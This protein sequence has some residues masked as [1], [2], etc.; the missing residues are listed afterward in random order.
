MSSSST[1]R[2]KVEKIV[3]RTNE[4]IHMLANEP[5]VG[6]FHVQVLS[7]SFALARRNNVSMQDH[8]VRVLPG[9]NE[10]RSQVANATE[11]VAGC[12]VDVDYSN[13]VLDELM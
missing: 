4:A 7:F 10:T 9:V 11:A 3:Q 5:S 1:T 6:L 12:I 8:V 2:D 13:Q